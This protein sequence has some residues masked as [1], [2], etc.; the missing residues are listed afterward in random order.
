MAHNREAIHGSIFQ[1]QSIWTKVFEIFAPDSLDNTPS[2]SIL[3]TPRWENRMALAR[4]A[5]TCRAFSGPALDVLWK[6]IEELPALLRL[7]P[8][9]MREP[10][11]SVW[12]CPLVILVSTLTL[13]WLWIRSYTVPL[14]MRNGHG[15]N[16]TQSEFVR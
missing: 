8:S 10:E 15:S 3:N 6:D 7:F 12:V 13:T 5:R 9:Y 2:P 1:N 4:A 14:P 16:R 11:S